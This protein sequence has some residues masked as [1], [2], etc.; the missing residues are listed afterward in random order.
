MKNFYELSEDGSYYRIFFKDGAFFLIDAGDFDFVSERTWFHGKRGYPVSHT[1]RKSPEG[2]K[3]EP[4]HKYLLRP[5]DGFD[6]DHISGNKLDNRRRNLRVCSH[7]QNMFNQKLRETNTTGYRGVSYSK[8]A[9]KY[10]AYISR[11][12]RK[13]HLGLFVSAEEAAEVRDNAAVRLF[14]EYAG[15]NMV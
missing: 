11:D 4:L 5:D 1:S 3:T 12:G 13:I 2:Q 15:L 6:V 7:Q 8:N 10:E 14:G 9:G